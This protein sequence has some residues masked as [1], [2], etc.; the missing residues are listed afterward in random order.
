V[1]DDD[2]ATSE[3]GRSLVT[4]LN[5]YDICQMIKVPTRNQYIL[6]L[7]LTNTPDIVGGVQ[8]FSSIDNLDHDTISGFLKISHSTQKSFKR[9]VRHFSVENLTS[10][11]IN[12]EV[13]PWHTLLSIDNSLDENINT[14]YKILID[15]LNAT[16]P[17]KSIT[18]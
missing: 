11:N 14:F 16:I 7:L 5:D 8:V 10:L 17:L 3:L 12:L 13:V 6:D 2:H 18:V 1:W 9:L 4:I 15:E